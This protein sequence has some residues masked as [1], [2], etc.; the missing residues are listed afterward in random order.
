MVRLVAFAVGG[1]SARR[2]CALQHQN[3]GLAGGQQEQQ[4]AAARSAL[5]SRRASWWQPFDECTTNTACAVEAPAARARRVRPRGRC[6]R[7][8][9]LLLPQVP[10]GA[11][12]VAIAPRVVGT[13]LEPFEHYL[14]GRAVWPRAATSTCHSGGQPIPG[15]ALVPAWRSE[16]PRGG[17]TYPTP[18]SGWSRTSGY[19]PPCVSETLLRLL[20]G[21]GSGWGDGAPRVGVERRLSDPA[22]R[23]ERYA[24]AGVRRWRD[25]HGSY[26]VLE[27]PFVARP[28]N[29]SRP[30]AV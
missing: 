5:E 8:A 11:A 12:A 25:R 26:G 19:E 16:P 10:E 18:P 14:V 17:L 7:G 13:G 4:R 9:W 2:G 23:R 30:A 24:P 21:R 1:V 20:A 15:C 28:S 27:S 22:V 6:L 29:R 3:G